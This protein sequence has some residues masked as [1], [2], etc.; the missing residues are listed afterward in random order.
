MNKQLLTGAL[1]FLLSTA[2]CAPASVLV[3]SS[4]GSG[5]AAARQGAAKVYKFTH[6]GIQFTV[7]AG[8]D[9]KAEKDSVKVL[10]KSGSAQIAFVALPIPATLDKDQ[11]A[12]LFDSL[13]IHEEHQENR[14]ST[15]SA[16]LI[17]GIR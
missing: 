8:W 16:Q 17:S 7:P 15:K 2:G 14:V 1:C 12:S 5:L 11:R 13:N 4:S 9:V 10:P 3:T 6:G